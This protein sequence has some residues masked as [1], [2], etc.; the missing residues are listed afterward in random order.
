[1]QGLHMTCPVTNRTWCQLGNKENNP[2]LVSSETKSTLKWHSRRQGVGFPQ[3]QHAS[4]GVHRVIIATPF[5]D[6]DTEALKVQGNMDI[7]AKLWRQRNQA[8]TP[9]LQAK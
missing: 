8:P 4:S 9:T 7:T 6:Q 3:A 5:S 2:M 1:M